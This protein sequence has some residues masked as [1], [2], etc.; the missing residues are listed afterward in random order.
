MEQKKSLKEGSLKELHGGEQMTLQQ[1]KGSLGAWRRD[2]QT[3]W[4]NVGTC[5]QMLVM[6]QRNDFTQVCLVRRWI[7]LHYLG[8]HG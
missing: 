7:Y 3:L 5:E 8:V 4:Y 2:T 1:R 6:D